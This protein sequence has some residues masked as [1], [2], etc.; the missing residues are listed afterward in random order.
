[1]QLGRRIKELRKKRNITQQ[2]LAVMLGVSYQAI[3]RWENNI[4]SPDITALPVLAN[5]FNVTVDYLLDVNINENTQ[6]IENIYKQS[7][8]LC[9]NQKHKEA[10]ELLEEKTKLFPNN[11]FLKN[12]LLNIYY[13][14]MYDN[15][16]E[17]YQAKIIDLANEIINNCLISDYKFSAIKALILIYGSK[18]EFTKGKELLELLPDSS[19]SKDYLKE[20][21]LTGDEK[22]IAIQEQTDNILSSFEHI[23]YKTMFKKPVGERSRYLQ[24]YIQLLDLIYDNKD[25]GIYNYNL[26]LIYLNCAKD[27]ADI[28]DSSE[29]LKYID[30]AKRHLDSLLKLKEENKL[31]RYSSFMVNKLCDCPNDW[32]FEKESMLGEFKKELENSMFD[33][34][35]KDICLIIN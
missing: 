21:T 9:V 14:L 23:I 6:I 31:I 34:V 35:R 18:K 20:H 25:Y 16:K 33:F 26:Y 22:E 29:T 24:K 28:K 12:E 4:T 1:M 5:I 17:I 3:S 27:Y 15:D 8:E 19:Y 32:P 11:Y 2:D 10:Q 13:V 30:L 7:W